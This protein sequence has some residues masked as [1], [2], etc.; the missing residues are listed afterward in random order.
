MLLT[1]GFTC[2]RCKKNAERCV[3]AMEKLA[4]TTGE[5]R[6][7]Q[8]AVSSVELS[9]GWRRLFCTRTIREDVLGT[10]RASE[11][12]VDD[13]GAMRRRPRI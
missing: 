13:W 4:Q 6:S 9:T 2:F 5:T 7:N 8:Q 12:T 11:S 1:E 3:L 10:A